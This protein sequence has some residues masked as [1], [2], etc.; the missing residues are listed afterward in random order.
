MVRAWMPWSAVLAAAWPAAA[1]ASGPPTTRV[2]DPT[3]Y[4]DV[5]PIV[6]TKCSP[7]HAEGGIAALD[8]V[9]LEVATDFAAVMAA[10]T[11]ARQMPPFPPDP[12]CADYREATLRT[13]SEDQLETLQNWA[14]AGA[15]A[16][17][18]DDAP[19]VPM[20]PDDGLGEP[21]LV[22][23]NDEPF[24]FNNQADDVYWCFRFDPG[25]DAP[26]D[27]VAAAV[28]PENLSIVHHVIV[29]REPEGVDRKPLGTPGFACGGAPA[30]GE[31][32]IGWA[33]G[34]APARLPEGYGIRLAEDDALIMQVHYHAYPG[35]LP[36]DRTRVQLW[37]AD[38]PVAK[39]VEVVWTG[40]FDI[41]VPPGLSQTAQGACRV[42]ED[43]DPVEL[44]AVAPHMH[45]SGTAFRS[46]VE[47]TDG[48]ETCLVDI[49]SWQFDWQGAYNFVQPVILQPGDVLH[50][51]CD[52][53]NRGD[54]TISWGEG[55]DDEMCFQ[56]NFVVQTEDIPEL[57]FDT[58]E[59]PPS[60]CGCASG[61][62]GRGGT[63]SAVLLV[64]GLVRWR[65]R[66]LMGR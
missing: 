4:R 32:L 8:L 20:P 58:V 63:P 18:P 23:E 43:A 35:A 17:D 6:H 45:R 57:C 27:I 62:A 2:E 64:L 46:H 66:R 29:F 33:P 53:H 3:Y 54:D 44:L 30:D 61:P 15:P 38:Q 59:E 13:L 10:K 41:L 52:F 65:R 22:L 9:E 34:T 19:P 36:T 49:P 16:G 26:R 11:Q 7:C 12:A 48:S 51:A 21:D 31:F 14:D 39:P 5:L 24:Y 47:R 37:L 56:F 25:F 28:A 60:G 42:P 40:S 55:S 1:S 50:T